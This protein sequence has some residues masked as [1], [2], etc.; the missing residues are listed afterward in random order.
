MRGLVTPSFIRS[1]RFVPPPRKA[2]PGFSVT[3]ANAPSTSS[4]AS[5]LERPSRLHYLSNRC[6]DVAVR[7]TATEIPAHAFSNLGVVQIRVS[8]EVLRDMTG[9]PGLYLVEHPHCR[10]HLSR[11]AVPALERILVEKGLLYGMQTVVAR[12]TV[13]RGDLCAVLCHC[14]PSNT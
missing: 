1:T 11:G 6:D 7:S 2:A 9:V 3:R 8:I 10:A 12:Q 4:G 5:V 14:E 13:C